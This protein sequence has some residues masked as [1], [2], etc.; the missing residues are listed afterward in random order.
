MSDCSRVTQ[1]RSAP[2]VWES[3]S[4]AAK[5]PLKH[6]DNAAIAGANTAAQSRSCSHRVVKQQCD[7]MSLDQ[8]VTTLSLT[9]LSVRLVSYSLQLQTLYRPLRSDLPLIWASV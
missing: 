6:C 3:H 8:D 4:L 7:D 5:T 9:F 1:C 2:A